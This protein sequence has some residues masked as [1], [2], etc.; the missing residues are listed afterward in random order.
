L[1]VYPVQHLEIYLD[2]WQ[3]RTANAAIDWFK[4]HLGEHGQNPGAL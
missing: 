1:I 4:K 2:P 3:T